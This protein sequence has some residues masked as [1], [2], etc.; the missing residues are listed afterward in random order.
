VLASVA[1]V[2]FFPDGAPADVGVAERGSVVTE[3]GMPGVYEEN[4]V[5]Q[6][7]H[8][9]RFFRGPGTTKAFLEVWELLCGLAV[10]HWSFTS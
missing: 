4:G 8:L 10:A 5:H 7:L 3:D 1:F 9:A 6:V 2:D